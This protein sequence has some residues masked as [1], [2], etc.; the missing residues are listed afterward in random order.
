MGQAR[1]FPLAPGRSWSERRPQPEPVGCRYM[2]PAEIRAALPAPESAA[3]RPDFAATLRDGR[4]VVG[5]RCDGDW[6]IHVYSSDRANRLL[7]YGSART[8]RCALEQAGLAGDEVG[9]L[10][11]R[12]GV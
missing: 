4:R 11:G 7:G 2:E 3:A 9:E 12:A 10:L 6:T 1:N 8:R 5:R